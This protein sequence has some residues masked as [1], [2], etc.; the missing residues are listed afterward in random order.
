MDDVPPYAAALWPD[1][2][3]ACG[4]RLRPH[5]LGHALLLQRLRSPFAPG[6][7]APAGLGELV[8]AAFVCSRSWRAAAA[9]INRPGFGLWARW[10][11]FRRWRHEGRDAGAFRAYLSAAWRAPK[12]WARR[13]GGSQRGTDPVQL[14]IVT[15]RV[16]WQKPLRVAL[17]TPVAEAILD[18]LEGLEAGGALRL[19]NARDHEMAERLEG[20]LQ[21]N[22]EEAVHA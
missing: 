15:Q 10:T 14:L 4:L 22:R 2:V 8:L 13:N 11:A 5:S 19:W 7:A 20:I 18:H 21:R 9:G 16:R 17:D 3:R 1:S 6:S 12:S